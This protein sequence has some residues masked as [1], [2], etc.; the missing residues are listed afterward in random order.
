MCKS[1]KKKCLSKVS[2]ALTHQAED[3]EVWT[4]WQGFPDKFHKI[5]LNTDRKGLNLFLFI[6]LFILNQ[7][8]M[9]ANLHNET[10]QQLTLTSHQCLFVLVCRQMCTD[11]EWSR[12]M[13]R[14]LYAYIMLLF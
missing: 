10:E 1:V 5:F 11:V 13:C 12:C 8:E 7:P 4:T 14:C 3:V 9:N 2:P 6:Y